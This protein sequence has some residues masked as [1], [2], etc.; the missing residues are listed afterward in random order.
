MDEYILTW[1]KKPF[2]FLPYLYT[3]FLQF[4]V[5]LHG[6]VVINKTKCNFT[7]VQCDYYIYYWVDQK[8]ATILF[9]I[10]CRESAVVR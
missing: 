1:K 9:S 2:C 6:I 7:C 5:F 8:H 3:L 4:P 10:F